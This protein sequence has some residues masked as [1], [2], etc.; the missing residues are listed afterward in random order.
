MWTN[1][2]QV[3]TIRCWGRNSTEIGGI[4]MGWLRRKLDDLVR[5]KGDDD[6]ATIVFNKLA[7]R[8]RDL[9]MENS[10]MRR[11]LDKAK[12]MLRNK[13]MNALYEANSR[14]ESLEKELEELKE[15]Q[16]NFLLAL[17]YQSGYGQFVINDESW[18][19]EMVGPDD[20]VNIER[21]EET[22]LTRYTLVQG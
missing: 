22:K 6:Y 18:E 11:A 1:I 17:C 13:Q 14:I 9:E 4:T 21:D 3:V 10:K 16:H 15:N 2:G 5:D 8:I 19:K 12:D 7:K 20:S